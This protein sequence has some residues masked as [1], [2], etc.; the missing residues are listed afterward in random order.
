MKKVGIVG[1]GNI[2]RVHAWVLK[3]LEG[4]E[5][6]SFADIIKGR[7]TDFSKEYTNG[8]ARAYSS[9]TSMLENEKMDIVH[10]C[11]PHYLHVPMIIE[12]LNS[13]VSAFSEKP[14]AISMDGFEQLERCVKDTSLTVGFCF[15]NRYNDTVVKAKEI[16][17]GKELGELIGG[18]AFVTWKRDEDYYETDW[19][20]R[21]A[22]EGGGALI[23]QSIHTL[24]LLL[25][26]LG[27][28]IDVQAS[29][30]NHHLKNVIEVEDTVEAWLRFEKGQRACF[31][32]STAYAKDAPVIIELQCEEGVISII[33]K[34][35]TVRK[36][37]SKPEHYYF[38]EKQGI[39]KDYWGNGHLKCIKDYYDKLDSN[40]R[41]ANDIAG[42]KNTMETMMKIYSFRN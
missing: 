33:D 12:T 6:V 24:D 2:A 7:A 28:P 38:E 22:T 18:R 26:F 1:C 4:V 34:E 42:V 25:E 14:P 11:T 32:A 21:L 23:N 20:G 41:F 13:G 36:N 9:L 8:K 19:K 31:Y 15:Q 29:L 35:L 27:T 17:A 16:I 5:I 10:I 40:E 37:G 3:Q 30:S 39:G